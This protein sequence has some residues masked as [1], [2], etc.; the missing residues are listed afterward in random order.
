MILDRINPDD[1]FPTEHIVTSVLGVMPYQ[2]KD[3]AKRFDAAYVATNER[4]I[5]NVDMDGQFYYRNIQFNEIKAIKTT[6]TAL[7]IKFD[8]GVFTLEESDADKVKAMS[9]YLHT[10][11]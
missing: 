8:Y 7:E 2:M 10:K 6:D 9:N 3:V 5:L 1:L 11:I 4:L